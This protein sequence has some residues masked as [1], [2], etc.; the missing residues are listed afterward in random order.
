MKEENM[1]KVRRVKTS[2]YVDE[3][4][5]R[6]FVE[7]VHSINSTTCHFIE[8]YCLS[9]IQGLSKLE[10]KPILPLTNIT[11]NMDLNVQRVVRR[12]KKLGEAEEKI[13]W[14]GDPSHCGE[15]GD[16]VPF[17]VGGY[18]SDP[19][20]HV[21]KYLCVDCFRFCSGNNELQYWDRLK[22]SPH[23]FEVKESRVVKEEIVKNKSGVPLR[24][25]VE[26]F[27]DWIGIKIV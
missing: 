18:R 25:D 17:Y 12:R 22:V 13:I 4:I 8:P 3:Q 20:T 11:F 5:W 9:V 16:G 10:S 1:L 27:K 21:K 2:I 19:F 26:D 14:R 6:D 7:S 23:G 24:V 15:C